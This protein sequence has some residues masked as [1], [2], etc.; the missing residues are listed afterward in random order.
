[1]PHDRLFYAPG[2]AINMPPF[3]NAY[4][5]HSRLSE[6]TRSSTNPDTFMKYWNEAKQV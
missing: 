6:Y 1:M 4:G 5:I 2:Q 3:D